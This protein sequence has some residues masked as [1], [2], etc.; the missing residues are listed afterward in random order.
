[1]RVHCLISSNGD[2]LVRNT[3]FDE[4]IG[5]KNLFDVYE[6]LRWLQQ[7]SRPIMTLSDE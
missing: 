3:D 7:V 6:T 1:M 5:R 4:V 2:L